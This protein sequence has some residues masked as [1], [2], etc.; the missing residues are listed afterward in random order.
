MQSAAVGMLIG[1]SLMVIKGNIVPFLPPGQNTDAAVVAE[2][3]RPELRAGDLLLGTLPVSGP[4]MYYNFRLGVSEDYWATTQPERV[5]V[6][7]DKERGV[8]LNPDELRAGLAGAF[9]EAYT[10]MS[11]EQFQVTGVL[12]E[13]KYAEIVSLKKKSD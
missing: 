12:L 13:T 5:L 4:L 3:L 2:Y 10:P 6:V 8:A 7:I 9:S 11:Q 1:G